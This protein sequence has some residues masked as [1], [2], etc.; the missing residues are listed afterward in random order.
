MFKVQRD[1]AW[2]GV[3]AYRFEKQPVLGPSMGDDDSMGKGGKPAELDTQ[4]PESLQTSNWRCWC[5]P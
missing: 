3:I 5:P 2:Q 1:E 4:P